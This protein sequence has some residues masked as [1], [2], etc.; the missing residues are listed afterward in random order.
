MNQC[1]I[2]NKLSGI[3]LKGTLYVLFIPGPLGPG[4]GG[5][6]ATISGTEV[7]LVVMSQHTLSLPPYKRDFREFVDPG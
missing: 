5:S 7:L 1:C 6:D 2:L 4:I 3:G